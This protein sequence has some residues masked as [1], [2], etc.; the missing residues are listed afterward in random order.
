MKRLLFVAGCL[1]AACRPDAGIPDYSGHVGL[2]DTTDAGDTTLP[3]PKPYDPAT[4][5]LA[6]GAFYEGEYSEQIAIND[7][8]TH[9]YIFT[10]EGTGE[11]TYSQ[12]T[13]GERVEGRISDVLTLTGTP[14]WGGGVIWDTARD[15]SAWSV[16]AVS[17]RSADEAF[18]DVE[19]TVQYESGGQLRTVTLPA[20]GYGYTNDGNWHSLRIP[21]AD[22]PG[23]D[24]SAARSPL[25]LGNG[26][27]GPT[28][29]SLFVD[30]VYME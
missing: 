7:A 21:L 8:D 26:Q 22:F 17:L 14:W 19:V 12:E 2:R 23:F 15:L 9:Y 27:A 28:G 16:L 3:G 11:L 18:D 4:P 30:D 6:I 24:R 1:A 13:S 29:E 10:I 25:I 20:S 5:R